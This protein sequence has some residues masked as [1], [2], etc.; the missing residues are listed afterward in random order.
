MAKK[1]IGKKKR[2]SSRKKKSGSLTSLI[3]FILVLIL[4]FFIVVK[5]ILPSSDEKSEAETQTEQVE[6]IV[7][8]DIE[9]KVE[10]N[11]VDDQSNQVKEKIAGPWMST[12]RGAYIEFTGNSYNVDFSGVDVDKPFSGKYQV[13]NNTITF[14]NTEEPCP[15]VKGVYEVKFD[16]DYIILKCKKDDCSRRKDLL[17]TKWEKIRL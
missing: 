13:D 3:L 1:S 6:D 8:N 9:D 4:A 7:V 12:S 11:C 14:S 15:D 2:S 17:E 16:E 10:V 5:Y